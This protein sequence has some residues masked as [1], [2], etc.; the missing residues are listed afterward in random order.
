MN[1]QIASVKSKIEEALKLISY[2]SVSGD[3]VD[4]MCIARKC[5][6]DALKECEQSG[7]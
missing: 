7:G 1:E 4:Y 3:A 6:K 2:I 5:L